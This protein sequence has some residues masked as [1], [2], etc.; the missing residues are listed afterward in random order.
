[1]GSPGGAGTA[2]GSRP[3]AKAYTVA[4]ESTDGQLIAVAG[5]SAGAATTIHT[6]PADMRTNYQ[7]VSVYG[8]NID[9]VNRTINLLPGAIA[10]KDHITRHL[11]SKRGMIRLTPP[12]GLKM[13]RGA[14]LKAFASAT[15]IVNLYVSV[16]E[17]DKAAQ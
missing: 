7:M 12:G 9:T 16:G 14:V 4:S 10:T 8:C 1:M 13:A 5:T 11:G 6:V 3:L 2:S 17:P 15:N